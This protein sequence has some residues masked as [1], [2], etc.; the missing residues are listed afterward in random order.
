MNLYIVHRSIISQW[1]KNK[2]NMRWERS[3][4][5]VSGSFISSG[6][7]R[8]I[9][10]VVFCR[11]LQYRWINTRIGKT[12]ASSTCWLTDEHIQHPCLIE[13]WW[14]DWTV[15]LL[16][17]CPIMVIYD[18]MTRTNE[19][20]LPFNSLRSGH[21][22]LCFCAWD[23]HEVVFWIKYKFICWSIK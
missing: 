19:R 13:I 1:N 7:W 8:Q 12:Y 21:I 11:Y 3:L 10:Y 18:V 17:W 23:K 22:L 4:A 9:E 15:L 16:I 20:W 14:S 2:P 5:S 6:S